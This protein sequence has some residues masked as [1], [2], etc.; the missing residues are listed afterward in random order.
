MAYI[1]AA[2]ASKD[3]Q[4]RADLVCNGKYDQE[5]LELAV[6]LLGS[7]GAV[8]LSAGTFNLTAPIVL[9][10]K[11]IKLEGAGPRATLLRFAFPGTDNG[12]ILARRGHVLRDFGI[13]NGGGMKY[14]VVLEGAY[15][16]L[17][18]LYI[19]AP[20]QA[21]V[22]GESGNSQNV[23]EAVH[24]WN[25]NLFGFHLYGIA[26]QVCNCIASRSSALGLAGEGFRLQTSGGVYSGLVVDGHDTA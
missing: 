10:D 8:R 7:G 15:N 3:D 22:R 12:I 20:D 24:V 1:A 23:I 25:S 13:V 4:K 17:D 9:G 5:Q 16:R 14:G 11:P 18:N 26:N 21:G 19:E 2:D 6:D